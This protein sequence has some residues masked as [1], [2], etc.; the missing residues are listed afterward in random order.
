MTARAAVLTE[1]GRRIRSARLGLGLIQED[2]A[3]DAGL[4]REYVSTIE[5]GLRNPGIVTV[6]RIGEAVGVDPAEFVTGLHLL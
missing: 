5:R 1:L 6:V 2:V 3:V 4:T